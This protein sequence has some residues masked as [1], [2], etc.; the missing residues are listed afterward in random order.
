MGGLNRAG[1]ACGPR[2]NRETLQVERDH[3]RLAIDM[4]KINTRRVRHARRALAIHTGFLDLSENSLLQA[5]AQR[6]HFLVVTT[7]EALHRQ[8]RSLSKSGDSRNILSSSAARA[9][10]SPAVKQR[11]KMRS[12]AHV[13][14]A[15]TLWCVHLVTGD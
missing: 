3:H 9:F 2:G 12:L 7:L 8:L 1:R 6:G 13:E 5:V 10:M 15:H 4:I 14:R 11:L